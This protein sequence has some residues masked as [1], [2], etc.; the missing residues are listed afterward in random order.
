ME[1]P[2][3]LRL[4]AE[5]QF[6][7]IYHEHFSYFS[8]ATVQRV[9]AAHQLE[10]F[11]VSELPTHGGSLRIF[12]RHGDDPSRAV[13][14]RVNGLLAAEDEAGL[15]RLET[16]LGFEQRVR[17]TKRRLL[18]FLVKLK[19]EGRSIAA[20][21]APAKGNTLLNYCG[22]GRDFIDYAVDR[23]PHKQG[24]LLPGS[25]IPVH[26]PERVWET[27][28]DYLFILPWN[29]EREIIEQMAGVREWGGKFFVAIPEVEVR[30]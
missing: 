13:T 2:H 20:Y 26:P 16:Y 22:I 18:D 25:R 6:D 10:I 19:D 14:A 21:G 9:F 4:I 3:L 1:F 28:P 29:L 27:R 7:T 15:G 17:R 23:S 30:S 5:N 11:D 8:F 12:A 24:L